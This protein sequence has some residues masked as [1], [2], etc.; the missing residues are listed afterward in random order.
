M[1]SFE[2][3]HD[4]KRFLF[5][6]NE[7]FAGIFAHEW[8]RQEGCIAP[9]STGLDSRVSGNGERIESDSLARNK[10]ESTPRSCTRRLINRSTGHYVERCGNEEARLIDHEAA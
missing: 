9:R 3:K 2:G 1:I 7:Y 5:V 6:V 10:N 8:E 4:T